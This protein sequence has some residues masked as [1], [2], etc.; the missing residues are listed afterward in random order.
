VPVGFEE[1]ASNF[2]FED[3]ASIAVDSVHGRFD[4]LFT[5]DSSKTVFTDNSPKIRGREREVLA[6][7]LKEVA[8]RR[9]AG[10]FRR[11]PFKSCRVC[12]L[13]IAPKF[14]WDSS[15]LEFRLISDFSCHG[16]SSVN[17]LCWSP[18][19]LAQ[20]FDCRM[21]ASLL[22]FYGPGAYICTRDIPKCFRGQGLHASMLPLCVYYI[23]PEGD[24]EGRASTLSTSAVPSDC[25]LASTSG[26]AVS[27]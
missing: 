3:V 19:L 6:H 2:P 8:A 17:D 11:P 18:E 26:N 16:C 27:R 24:E 20:Y 25:A 1:W 7:L 13:S 9:M 4:T 10:P 14:K 12:K 5:G 22:A 23:F 15:R 21:L